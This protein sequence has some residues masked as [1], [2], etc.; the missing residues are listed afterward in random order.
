MKDMVR[1]FKMEFGE[2]DNIVFKT[3]EPNP[4]LSSK[5]S[6]LSVNSEYQTTLDKIQPLLT[7]PSYF[8]GGEREAI[9]RLEKKVI[10]QHDYVNNFNKPKSISTNAKGNPFEPTTTG[11]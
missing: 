11:L 10:S 4:S 2:F 5:K 6:G 9:A 8:R 3:D 7:M 1:L